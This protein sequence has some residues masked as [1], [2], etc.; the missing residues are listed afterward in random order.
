MKRVIFSLYIDIPKEDL[1]IFDEH[2]LKEGEQ[3][4]QFITKQAFI[5]NY[6]RLVETKQKYADTIGADFKMFE[7]D[8]RYKKYHEHFKETYPQITDYNIV[9]FYKLDLLF[10]LTKEYDQV[11]YLDF[12]AVP[13][14]NESFFDVWD[15]SKGIAILHNNDRIKTKWDKMTEM[16]HT[17]RSPSSKYFNCQAMLLEEGMS[18]VN[19]VINTG[20]V[21]ID[22]KHAEMLDYYSDFDDVLKLMDYLRTDDY[23]DNESMFPRNLSD[24]FGYDNETIFGYKIKKNNVPILWLNELEGTWHHFYDNELSIPKDTK[25]IHAINKK[26]DFIWRFYE[27]C[28]L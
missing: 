10:D 27:K 1:D 20:I 11:L 3:S 14:T 6:D 19:D 24:N 18:P 23:K 26:F 9:N 12:D 22:R 7:Y 8:E 17:I 5:D 25:I 21:G 16:R 13:C 2:I 28:N 4:Q 15:L